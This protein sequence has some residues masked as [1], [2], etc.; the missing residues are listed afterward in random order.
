MNSKFIVLKT[1]KKCQVC[2]NLCNQ[3]WEWNFCLNEDERK[4]MQEEFNIGR[5][6]HVVLL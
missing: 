2:R 6:E 3:K 4:R 1:I 5:M